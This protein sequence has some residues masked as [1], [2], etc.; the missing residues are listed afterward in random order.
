[1][2]RALA[3][4]SMSVMNDRLY[5]RD[6]HALCLYIAL[7]RYMYI[8][9]KTIPQN[10]YYL[11]EGPGGEKGWTRSELGVG[12]SVWGEED[13]ASLAVVCP[14]MFP[15]KTDLHHRKYYNDRRVAWQL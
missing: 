10:L 6:S 4:R 3:S 13:G 9:Q 15:M 12:Y 1:M 5:V 2:K 14:K 7:G 11:G 8:L